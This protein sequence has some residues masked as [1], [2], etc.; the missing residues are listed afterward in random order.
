MI[1]KIDNKK[2]VNAGQNLKNANF[3]DINSFV[4]SE[5]GD[6]TSELAEKAPRSASTIKYRKSEFEIWGGR[7][8]KPKWVKEV[9]ENGENLEVYRVQEEI[10]Q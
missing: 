1:K 2:I 10:T 9:E 8:P 6:P 3:L 4:G 5:L 7:G